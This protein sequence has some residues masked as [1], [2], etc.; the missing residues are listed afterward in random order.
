MF[1]FDDAIMCCKAMPVGVKLRH[2]WT[3]MVD[4]PGHNPRHVC[5]VQYTD[6][7]TSVG[8]EITLDLKQKSSMKSSRD[9]Y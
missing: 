1:P 8:T 9:K 2:H 6:I 3:K 7:M 5:V 4:L